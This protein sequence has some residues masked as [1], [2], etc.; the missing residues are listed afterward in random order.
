MVLRCDDGRQHRACHQLL[1]DISKVSFPG[2]GRLRGDFALGAVSDVRRLHRRTGRPLR[3]PPPHTDRNAAV[4]GRFYLLGCDVPERLGGALE[5]RAAAR[6]PRAGGGHLGARLAG[7]DQSDRQRQPAAERRADER[8]RPLRGFS[9][10]TRGGRRF[11][12]GI[13]RGKRHIHQRG[14]L[15]SL[16]RLVDRSPLRPGGGGR[17]SH[18]SRDSSIS[19]PP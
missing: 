13:R 2:P 1:G 12:A 18:R 8:D 17:R 15:R 9:G 3:H 11:A 10:R 16:V 7:I 4:H 14:D 5:G 19:G 6:H